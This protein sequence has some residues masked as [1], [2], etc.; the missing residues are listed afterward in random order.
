M[1]MSTLNVALPIH[2]THG[3]THWAQERA[4]A[5]ADELVRGASAR[6]STFDWD[7]VSPARAMVVSRWCDAA[8]A[9]GSLRVI[10]S[11]LEPLVDA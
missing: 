6:G 1:T 2:T 9:M 5:R 10:E 4:A 11:S 7:A 8:R 3:A